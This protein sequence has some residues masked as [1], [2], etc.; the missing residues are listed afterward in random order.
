LRNF[1]FEE[2]FDIMK[3]K[4]A[5]SDW[6]VASWSS[7]HLAE[8]IQ[9][10]V[11][12]SPEVILDAPW[13][14]STDIWNLGALVPELLYSQHMFNGRSEDGKYSDKRHL[15]E[16]YNL[17]G[18]FPISLLNKGDKEL[19]AACFNMDGKIL[20]P[21]VTTVG[22]EVRFGNIEKEERAEFISFIEAMLTIDS[23][24]RKSAKELLDMAWVR[25]GLIDAD[26]KE[27]DPNRDLEEGEKFRKMVSQG[28]LGGSWL[29]TR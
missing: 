19:V 25:H 28:G 29:Y 17:F 24:K 11:L 12:R 6:G 20:N 10:T 1:Y 14:I 5:L 8:F 15:E 4:I 22:F 9:P 7:K 18:P 27:E 26:D 16:I 2:G 21:V 3:L 23:A 13:D